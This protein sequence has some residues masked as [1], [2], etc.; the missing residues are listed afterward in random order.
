[1]I[2][3][4][5]RRPVAAWAASL[6]CL[7]AVTFGSVG[8]VRA[9]HPSNTLLSF[10]LSGPIKPNGA[11]VDVFSGDWDN[12]C[13]TDMYE[14]ELAAVVSPYTLWDEKESC[15]GFMAYTDDTG[16]QPMMHYA[17]HP[18]WQV[19]PSGYNAPPVKQW[20]SDDGVAKFVVLWLFYNYPHDCTGKI[21]SFSSG[22][23]GDNERVQFVL[24]SY[25]LRTFYLDSLN[26]THHGNSYIVDGGW[27]KTFVSGIL[28]NGTP[29]RYPVILS[30]ADT[31]ASYPGVAASSDQ[32]G[33]SPSSYDQC[34][35][36][37]SVQ[38][39]MDHNQFFFPTSTR[40]VG[41][42]PTWP[43]GSPD[44]EGTYFMDYDP[45]YCPN[46]VL[47]YDSSAAAWYSS[48]YTGDPETY[49]GFPA[50]AKFTEYWSDVTSIPSVISDD[51]FCGWEC[52][53]L[54]SP[55]VCSRATHG[56][57]SCAGT[58]LKSILDHTTFDNSR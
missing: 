48:E 5:P 3:S 22:H 41:N 35:V 23:Q 51:T 37:P 43:N 17:P 10:T 1:M 47:F 44:S 9:Q 30:A 53:G 16:G 24:Y 42:S 6:T 56:N 13:L 14:Q 8:T 12:D 46:C 19:R 27:E 55:N 39:A 15:N 25:D 32:C 18:Y 36:G 58:A 34:T 52:P 29:A 38:Y 49:Y 50:R 4:H 11:C 7:A 20:R 26:V 21:T 33:G 57:S 28:R 45:T 54:S 40:M 31:H 2:N